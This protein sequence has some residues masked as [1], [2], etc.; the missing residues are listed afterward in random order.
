MWKID[1]GLQLNGAD[2]LARHSAVFRRAEAAPAIIILIIRRQYKEF[3]GGSADNHQFQLASPIGLARSAFSDQ[4]RANFA[5]YWKG[6]LIA[7]NPT[8]SLEAVSELGKNC[9]TFRPH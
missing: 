8:V 2:C 3:F 6:P 5:L 1:D 4:S 7:E 9:A